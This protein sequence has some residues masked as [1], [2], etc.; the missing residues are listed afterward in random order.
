MQLGAKNQ[1]E[2]KIF[3]GYNIKHTKNVSSEILRKF[4][5]ERWLVRI[6]YRTWAVI[7]HYG[8]GERER[9]ER[10]M[11][12]RNREK[13][14]MVNTYFENFTLNPPHPPWQ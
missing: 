5:L 8:G 10:G 4:S 3:L 12:F 2:K 14:N 9:G 1:N 6:Q 7:G 11:L 13:L